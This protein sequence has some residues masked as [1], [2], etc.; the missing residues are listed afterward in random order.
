MRRILAL[1]GFFLLAPS[2]WA[3]DPFTV[4][5]IRLEGIQ[6][7]EPGTVFNYLPVK[8]GETLTDD[9]AQQA[10]RALFA[11]GFF[12]DV[13]IEVQGEV[14]IVVVEERPAIA[15]IDFV[16]MKDFKGD[17]VK[18]SL[19]ET[20]I[21]EGRIF[22]RS[23]IDLA[24]QEIKRQYLSRGKYGVIITT[25][26]T[27]LDRNRVGVNFTVDE[28]E[29]AKIRAINIVGNQSFA[30]R[31]LLENFVLTT[32]GWLS[33]YTKNDQYSRQKLQ[34]DLENLRSFYLNRGYLDFN[35]DST[36]VS[37]TPD[38]RDIYITVNLSE[39]EKYTVSDVRLSGEF[40]VPAAELEKL[41]SIKQGDV[42]ARE[43]LTE[44]T[45]RITDRLGNDGYAFA[46]ANAVPEVDRD[47]R[48]VAFN[49]VVDPGRRVYV[50]RISVV[51][52][53]KTRDEV[54][55]REMRQLEGSFY[56]AQKL[57][58]SKRR[59]DRTQYFAEVEVETP[60]VPGTTDQVDAVIRVKEKPT[61]N[62]LVGVG[63]SSV[64]KI[65]LQ[66]SISQ[67]NIFGSGKTFGGQLSRGRVNRVAS[68]SYTDPYYT[69]DGVSQG[70]DAYV[71]ELDATA[72]NIG[73]Y[74]TDSLGFGVR[75]GVPLTENDS[76]TFGLAPDRTRLMLYNDSPTRFLDFQRQFG[77]SYTSMIGSAGLTTDTRDSGIWPTTGIV[78][79]TNL[80]AS[81]PPGSLRYYKLVVS[82][83]Q[84]FPLTR[85]T[86]LA[87]SGEIGVGDGYGGKPLPFF[88][89]FYAGGVGSVRGFSTSSLGPQD[90]LTNTL[91][92]NKRVMGS[93]E[94]LFP[95]PGQGRDRSFR[96]GTFIDAGQVFGT[97]QKLR[98]SDLRYSAGLSFAW[99]SPLGPLKIS[100]AYPLNDKL[101]DKVQRFQ[102]TF[103]QTF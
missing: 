76:V 18:K 9:R 85:D 64:D 8:V 46:N 25:T 75:W 53:T 62:I 32:P 68:V 86:T 65:V 100:L 4:R 63:L 11:T 44:S 13:R 94:Y 3:F 10:I 27:P 48:T 19:R 73:R 78:Q 17:E 15:S 60:A 20:G 79:R 67:T 29:V 95:L 99:N 12:R 82:R 61:G 84:F 30:E 22:D 52:N 49:I 7:I 89:N 88:R 71:R 23:Q 93:A 57:N 47:K 103:G 38:K 81:V 31:T 21:Q 83:L 101:T 33:W 41:V 14:M 50:R 43:K 56:D 90:A 34:G 35:I 58:V 91:G 98:L 96:V 74:K 80:E 69:V 97:D 2:A 24:E 16:G 26:V 66:G 28:G 45:K 51:G 92:G 42:F 102:F 70:F 37:I 39:G 1:W 36:Q 54:V 6:R 72:L 5:D 40:L 55:R 59:V 87:L 77:S